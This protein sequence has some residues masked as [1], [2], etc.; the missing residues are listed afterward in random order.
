MRRNLVV[1]SDGTGS[2]GG[3]AHTTSVWALY[4]QLER[5]AA[6]PGSGLPAQLACHDDGVGTQRAWPARLLGRLF[7]WGLY[8]NVRELYAFLVRSYAPGDALYLLGF[9]RGAYTV[10]T[11]AGLVGRFG[12]LRRERFAT[13]AAL[14][15]A[16]DA[17]CRSQRATFAETRRRRRADPQAG[18]EP[19]LLGGLAWDDFHH[20]PR[21]G[22]PH[23]V[24][25]EF[26]G[27]W[28]TVDAVGLP[29]DGAAEA[30]NRIFQWRFADR[31]PS[32]RLRCARQALALDDRRRT[33]QPE[34]WDLAHEPPTAPGQRPRVL[35]AWF[36]GSHG[37]VGGASERRQLG[38]VALDWML[39]EARASGLRFPEEA[40][41][42]IRA[43]ADPLGT[44]E[45][46]RR[47]LRALYRLRPRD[48]QAL[49]A[50]AG[51]P[52]ALL[53]ASVLERVR[54]APGGY[55]PPL[56]PVEAELLATARAGEAPPLPTP[57]TLAHDPAARARAQ[58]LLA[59]Q[60]RLQHAGWALLLLPLLLLAAEHAGAALEA[61][62]AGHGRLP[63]L[64]LLAGLALLGLL[65]LRL[66]EPLACG[67]ATGP[68]GPRHP[69]RVAAARTLVL[70][71]LLAAGLAVLAAALGL[72]GSGLRALDGRLGCGTPRRW[73]DLPTLLLA[74]GVGFTLLALAGRAVARR[75]RH[76]ALDALAPLRDAPP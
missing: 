28:D 21:A 55:A 22:R 7:G 2:R 14:E 66:A 58:A 23:G 31:R 3:R 71:A 51:Q 41:A 46:E 1:L 76:A 9:S 64:A 72:C 33:F 52:R 17:A 15:R 4:E 25:I 48:A 56:L 35:Q 29:S 65:A 20:E 36:A 75:L 38:G 45:D 74:W 44:L 18:E 73:L 37:D 69:L 53:H 70:A 13:A 42:R 16:L 6:P 39:A 5:G 68:A 11:L 27:V 8:A 59:L 50:A 61:A 24:D 62:C 34:L 32:A 10:R 40:H 19:L 57:V 12:I 63:V 30:L 26:L 43:Q 47:G 60:P 54:Q 67:R 49:A